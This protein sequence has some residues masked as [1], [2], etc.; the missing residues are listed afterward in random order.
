LIDEEGVS[1]RVGSIVEE[2]GSQAGRL[3]FVSDIRV[4]RCRVES[5]RVV[6]AVVR[7][8]LRISEDQVKFGELFRLTADGMNVNAAESCSVIARDRFES[9][10]Q[11][12]NTTSGQ[13]KGE[14]DSPNL[15]FGISVDELLLV[16][17]DDYSLAS[18]IESE[19]R[20]FVL[21][22][23]GEVDSI[24]NLDTESRSDRFDSSV[25]E[26]RKGVL[27][28]ESGVSLSFRKMESQLNLKMRETRKPRGR[29]TGSTCSKGSRGASLSSES[30]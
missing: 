16:A 25:S 9:E 24:E 27:V 19:L 2:Q 5:V 20:S 13:E 3:K 15:P 21:G 11:R 22:E 23:S 28:V 4:D 1:S 14:E 10:R 29:L 18:D 30:Q 6:D 8:L 12:L 7:V 26:E 17:K